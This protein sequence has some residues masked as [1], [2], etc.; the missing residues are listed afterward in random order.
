MQTA[1]KENQEEI[2]KEQ[3]E[4]LKKQD[5]LDSKVSRA[6][7]VQTIAASD[8]SERD[9]DRLLRCTHSTMMSLNEGQDR[10]LYQV[11]VA[12]ERKPGS[13]R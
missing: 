9:L 10:D 4:I 11:L 13:P 5:E 6:L 7:K 12:R 1:I 3:E 8:L 2:K